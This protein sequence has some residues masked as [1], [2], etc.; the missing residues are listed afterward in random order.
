MSKIQLKSLKHVFELLKKFDTYPT[1]SALT[2]ALTKTKI[3]NDERRA[4]MKTFQ[5]EIYKAK[6]LIEESQEWINTLI[7][8]EENKNK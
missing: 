2:D 3:P 6:K 4:I 8:D 5:D 1:Y 7:S